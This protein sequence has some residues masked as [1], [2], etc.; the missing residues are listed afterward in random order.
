MAAQVLTGRAGDTK[1]SRWRLAE[2][3]R[4]EMVDACRHIAV[5]HGTELRLSPNAP[6]GGFVR[7]GGRQGKQRERQKA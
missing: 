5:Q 2:I 6:A 4:R 1:L 7:T 3:S